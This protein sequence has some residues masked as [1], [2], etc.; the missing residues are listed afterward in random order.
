MPPKCGTC[1]ILVVTGVMVILCGALNVC[2]CGK[3]S[4]GMKKTEVLSCFY[5]RLMTLALDSVHRSVYIDVLRS[6][7]SDVREQRA[8]GDLDVN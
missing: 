8:H 5:D 4:F 2:C 3:M 7:L 1:T 6:E